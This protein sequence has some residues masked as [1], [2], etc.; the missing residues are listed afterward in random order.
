MSGVSLEVFV[1]LSGTPSAANPISV[2]KENSA[3]EFI[4]EAAC[5]VLGLSLLCPLDRYNH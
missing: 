2:P 5:D 1:T 3:E 4:R